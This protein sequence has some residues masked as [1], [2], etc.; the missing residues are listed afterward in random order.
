MEFSKEEKEKTKEMADKLEESTVYTGIFTENFKKDPTC[1]LQLGLAILMNKPIL[2]L[3]Q[4]GVSV[5]AAL[6][7]VAIVETF[8]DMKDEKEMERITATMAKIIKEV[9]EKK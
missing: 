4:E 8:K 6:A 1:A 2:L 5:P 3:V 7:K 9:N